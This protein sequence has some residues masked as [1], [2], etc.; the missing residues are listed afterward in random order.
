MASVIPKRLKD[1]IEIWMSEGKYGH[2]QINFAGGK[3]INVN[4]VESVKVEHIGTVTLALSNT[5]FTNT[6][7]KS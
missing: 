5:N 7:P 4:K 1:E 3:I 6:T 2:L